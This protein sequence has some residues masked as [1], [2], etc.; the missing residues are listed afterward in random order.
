[1]KRKIIFLLTI[2]IMLTC[3]SKTEPLKISEKQITILE[4]YG[5]TYPA[6]NDDIDQ[7]LLTNIKKTMIKIKENTGEYPSITYQSYISKPYI[8]YLINYSYLG[9]NNTKGYI[10]DLNSRDEV[11]LNDQELLMALNK[12]NNSKYVINKNDLG[13]LA[14]VIDDDEIIVH[15]SNYLT[16]KN[17]EKITIPRKEISRIERVKTNDTLKKTKMIAITF[18]DAPSFKTKEIV[19]LLDQ[20]NVSATFFVLGCN[21]VRYQDELRYII[22]HHHEIGN[23]SYSHPNFKKITVKEGLAEIAKTQ[24]TIFNITSYYPR[25]FRFPY[26]AVNKEVL[27]E[28][29][30]PTVL[31]DVDSLDWQNHDTKTIIKRV[32]SQV[33]ENSILLFHDF[34]YFNET[35]IKTLISDLRKDGYTF[36]NLSELMKFTTTEDLKTGIIHFNG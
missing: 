34:K 29:N 4:D 36:V 19:D 16:N 11:C 14:C 25:V 2:L 8:S 28:L 30:I 35:A 18:D 27:N 24:E 21:A 9:I 33:S 5:I 15:L 3:C 26:G 10:Y 32:K 13:F 22:S 20:L 7:K 12:A 6:I 23:H 17:G 1:M 31:W